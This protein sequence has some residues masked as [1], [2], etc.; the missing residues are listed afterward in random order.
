MHLAEVVYPGTSSNAGR[1]ATVAGALLLLINRRL[2]AN[3]L[4]TLF[5]SHKGPTNKPHHMKT[6]RQAPRNNSLRTLRANK[7]NPIVTAERRNSTIA[8][9]APAATRLSDAAAAG[10]AEV[11]QV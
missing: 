6:A 5:T 10:R 2:Q 11:R 4:R 8:L 7:A 1:T 3:P 9:R